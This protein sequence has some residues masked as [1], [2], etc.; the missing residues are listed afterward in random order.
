MRSLLAGGGRL[1]ESPPFESHVSFSV[2]I[3]RSSDWDRVEAKLGFYVHLTVY[4]LVGVLLVALD[5]SA[6]PGLTWAQWP[7]L[8]WG[9]GVLFHA[10]GVFVFRGPSAFTERMI[11]NEMRRAPQ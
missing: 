6:S 10:L 11:E 1:A 8:G 7:L 3:D 9:T 5:L 2:S 4:L